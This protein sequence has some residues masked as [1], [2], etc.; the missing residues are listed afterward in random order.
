MPVQTLVLNISGWVAMVILVSLLT[1]STI[2]RVLLRLNR[3]KPRILVSRESIPVG[4]RWTDAPYGIKM[5]D[6]VKVR[7]GDLVILTRQRVTS[8]N[9]IWVA[10]AGTWQRYHQLSPVEFG[11]WGIPT[12]GSQA[13]TLWTCAL[14][15]NW[16]QVDQGRRLLP[17]ESE[18][19]SPN[20]PSEAAAYLLRLGVNPSQIRFS[21]STCILALVVDRFLTRAQGDLL[22]AKPENL[23]TE[24]LDPSGALVRLT[25][26]TWSGQVVAH[27][28]SIQGTY[29]R[30]MTVEGYEERVSD[31]LHP[32]FTTIPLVGFKKI[33][34]D[35]PPPLPRRSRYERPPVI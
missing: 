15:F 19:F 33:I 18:D 7:E 13:G 28:A 30:L 5:V 12:A 2:A 26:Q 25:E 11:H 20:C 31:T 1:W 16:I 27:M 21:R 17:F 34:K 35:P 9:G 3:R 4:D 23:T 14:N 6:R 32:S 8:S 22:L 10:S 24:V 29:Q